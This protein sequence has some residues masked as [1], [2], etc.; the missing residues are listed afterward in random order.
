M[1]SPK[2]RLRSCGGP[3]RLDVPASNDSRGAPNGVAHQRAERYRMVR[4]SSRLASAERH[5]LPCRRH[6]R[7]P[8]PG[9]EVVISCKTRRRQ[10]PEAAN[11]LA[12][13]I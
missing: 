10:A 1:V 3:D 9:V 7:S 4:M 8:L 13:M 5:P 6:G 11:V 12:Q 2:D